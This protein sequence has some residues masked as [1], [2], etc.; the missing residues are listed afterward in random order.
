MWRA[1]EPDADP[2]GLK[3]LDHSFGQ[4]GLADSRF[5]FDDDDLSFPGGGKLPAAA[6]QRQL[7]FSAD[8]SGW[9]GVAA[10]QE[11]RDWPRRQQSP[12]WSFDA[13][14]RDGPCGDRFECSA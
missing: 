7:F 13:V 10:H 14:L 11:P 8:E 12:G 1:L 9:R 3:L 2:S 4:A 6:Q 5:T